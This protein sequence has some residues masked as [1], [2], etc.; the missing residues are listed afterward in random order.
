AKLCE[1]DLVWALAPAQDKDADFSWVKPGKVAWDWWNDYGHKGKAG[2]NTGTYERFIDFAAA[3]GLE[4]VIFDAG[5]SDG[6]NIW[7]YNPQ[8][9][10]PYLIDYAGKKGVGVILWM[11]WSEV[12]GNEER[13]AEHFS[14]LGAKGFKVDFMDRG[15]A[16]VA[17]FLE[18]FAAICAK[19]RMHLDYHGV[20]RPNGLHR[21]Y[22]NLLNYEGIHGLEQM[23]W[24]KGDE[25]GMLYN[26]VAACYLRMS[27]GPMDYTPGA[28]INF[29]VGSGRRG[30]NRTPGSLGTRARQMAMMALY[31][32]P[33]Q[34][35]CDSTEHYEANRESVTF[36]AKIP[37]VWK[38]TIGLA[39][40]PDTMFVAARETRD[41]AWYAG[42]IAAIWAPDVEL[43][44]AFLG[45]GEWTAEIFRDAGDAHGDAEKY[46]HET[47]TVKSGVKLP[48]HMAPGGGFIVRFSK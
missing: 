22:P 24:F 43:D 46:V 5:W 3:N 20:S 6:L 32:A 31:E 2:C 27:A 38:R 4:Y 16:G 37:T 18:R 33:L 39:G 47:R 40:T 35:F 42:G 30:S 29:G 14:K 26:D 10:V 17:R 25:Y 45:D 41:G 36:M 12:C 44:T 15:D 7:K 21:R 11:A 9:D 28:M 1:S 23:K 8:V 34:M 13:V 19:H 48:F